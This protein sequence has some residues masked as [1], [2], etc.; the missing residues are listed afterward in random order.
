MPPPKTFKEL[1]EAAI[2]IDTVTF[3]LEKAEKAQA[4]KAAKSQ[5]PRTSSQP[6]NHS[7]P[8]GSLNDQK[9]YSQST[10]PT[11]YPSF[12]S[13]RSVSV[14]SSA[15]CS[16]L[17]NDEKERRKREGLC[18]Y[19]GDPNHIVKQCPAALAKDA[20]QN[21]GNTLPRQKPQA[22]VASH[23]VILGNSAEVIPFRNASGKYDA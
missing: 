3:A 13:F 2:R 17:T 19:C 6:S 23:A 11:P 16:P 12:S 4:M 20:K 1:M 18:H 8:S 9:F 22:S 7:K 15:P 10:R 21:A 14:H 5:Q